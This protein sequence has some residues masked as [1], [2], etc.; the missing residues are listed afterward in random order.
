[1]QTRD[2]KSVGG[3]DVD[4]GEG[5]DEGGGGGGDEGRDEG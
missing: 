4:G 5:G 2:S 3:G 1:M